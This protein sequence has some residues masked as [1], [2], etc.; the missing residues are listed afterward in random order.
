MKLYTPYFEN[1]PRGQ[2]ATCSGQNN[3]SSP[4]F[5]RRTLVGGG[6]CFRLRG[7][8]WR[9]IKSY[10]DRLK[11]LHLR[12]GLEQSHLGPFCDRSRHIVRFDFDAVGFVAKICNF[13]GRHQSNSAGA[14][15]GR[16]RKKASGRICCGALPLQL[17]FMSPNWKPCFP[18]TQC[19]EM[20]SCGA[21]FACHKSQFTASI[22][23]L[24]YAK[25]CRFQVKSGLRSISDG[26]HN[27]DTRLTDSM[28]L[29]EFLR[30]L[31]F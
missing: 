27:A 20:T 23:A 28:P 12:G 2:R 25:F 1:L 15:D 11:L 9:L 7:C 17:G 13:F 14:D 31:V 18:L 10:N 26:I 8:G 16:T 4:R 3:L 22:R 5:R 21:R 24:K 19:G 29:A 30:E 6:W